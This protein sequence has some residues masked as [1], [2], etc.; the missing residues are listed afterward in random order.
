MSQSDGEVCTVVVASGVASDGLQ[1][2]GPRQDFTAD[3][4]WMHS[5]SELAI[6]QACCFETCFGLS[7]R[8]QLQRKTPETTKAT[9]K[10]ILL[11]TF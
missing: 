9:P 6:S 4:S 3:E 5:A 10:N 1:G 2:A 7:V 8:T 11:A